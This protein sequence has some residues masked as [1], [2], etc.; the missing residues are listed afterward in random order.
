M[1]RRRINQRRRTFR[2]LRSNAGLTQIQTAVR[3]EMSLSRYR[4]IENG[5]GG[6]ITERE[7]VILRRVFGVP[8]LQVEAIAS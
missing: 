6:P 4:E 2:V 3:A 8:E 7:S 1:Q 5:Y